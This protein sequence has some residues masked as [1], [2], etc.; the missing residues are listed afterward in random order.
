MERE[1]TMSKD[2]Y[3]FSAALL[4]TIAFL[5]QV[6]RTYKTKK[7]DDISL[8]MLLLFISGLMLWIVYAIQANSVPVLLANL[9]TLF[10]NCLI[11]VMKLIYKSSS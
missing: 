2:L 1:S 4:T 10:L 6:I 7:V 8:L 11:L 9:V 3:G 5:P